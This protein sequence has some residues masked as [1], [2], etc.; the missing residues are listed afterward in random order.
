MW[1]WWPSCLDY[2]GA[3]TQGVTLSF[4]LG[5]RL[6]SHGLRRGRGDSWGTCGG[7]GTP[8]ERQQGARH[9]SRKKTQPKTGQEKGPPMSDRPPRCSSGASLRALASHDLVC[10]ACQDHQS[11]SLQGEPE[12]WKAQEIPKAEG[13]THTD[14]PDSCDGSLPLP[15]PTYRR[16]SGVT[17]A[18]VQGPVDQCSISNR[19]IQ[20]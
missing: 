9:F 6:Q 14:M 4:F 12:A 20:R 19:D 16:I 8:A 2:S 17:L 1:V 7:G 11:D 13:T 18:Q 5:P 15:Y 10:L 3:G